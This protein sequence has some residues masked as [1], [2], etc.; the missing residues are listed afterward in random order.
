MLSHPIGRMNGTSFRQA[1]A[2]PAFIRFSPSL[3]KPCRTLT[4]R[5]P[6]MIEDIVTPQPGLKVYAS[7]TD[8]L[9]AHQA[10]LARHLHPLVSI[11]LSAID[12]YWEG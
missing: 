2:A 9:A 1:A 3:V 12:P 4:M 5:T 10:A 11:D 7:D 6:I 8:V